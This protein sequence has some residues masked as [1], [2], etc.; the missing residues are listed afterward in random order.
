[1][2]KDEMVRSE[3]KV[4]SAE[5]HT[6]A[7]KA[8]LPHEHCQGECV[9][10]LQVPQSVALEHGL[11]INAKNEITSLP[12]IIPYSSKDKE[13][14]AKLFIANNGDSEKTLLAIIE[15]VQKREAKE[16]AYIKA[17]EA[18]K[19]IDQALRQAKVPEEVDMILAEAKTKNI[20]KPNSEYYGGW[21]TP[22]ELKKQIQSHIDSEVAKQREAERLQRMTKL[23]W[24]KQ[25]TEKLQ[26]AETGKTEIDR[27]CTKFSLAYGDIQV[28]NI[29]SK[30]YVR[31][32]ATVEIS[33]AGN[34]RRLEISNRTYD[35]VGEDEYSQYKSA[36]FSDF[37]Y[38][39]AKA[40]AEIFQGEVK[41]IYNY[42]RR[43]AYLN[44]ECQ[45]DTIQ[46]AS[47]D[48]ESDDC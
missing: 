16:K 29:A 4:Y 24:V 23:P 2:Q 48:L 8:N 27:F 34:D 46:I 47:T 22:D 7:L 18:W 30:P 31:I 37:S 12:S 26:I 45:G 9:F 41:E 14:K 5:I 36:E 25:L 44:V 6:A 35:Q 13:E 40:L 10:V 1:M 21:G 38:A 42:D 15:A 17:V 28:Q 33:A 32:S 39:V 3:I 19:P 43:E 20:I 11:T